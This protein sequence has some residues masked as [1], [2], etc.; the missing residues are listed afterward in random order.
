MRGSDNAQLLAAGL[1]VL[2]TPIAGFDVKRFELPARRDRKR[3]T[4]LPAAAQG[5]D[6]EAFAAL[7]RIH[8]AEVFRLAYRLTRQRQDAEDVVQETFLRAY[9][10]LPQFGGDAAFGTWLHRIA[11]N[12][13]CD[14]LRTRQR[15]PGPAASL[16]EEPAGDLDALTSTAASP[17]RAATSAEAQRRIDAALCGLTASERTAFLL[18]HVEAMPI[19]E[20]GRTLGLSQG[21][22]KQAVFRAVRKLRQILTPLVRPR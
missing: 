19:E 20:I 2:L 3:D 6:M 21:A 11:I 16:D 1:G 12:C 22:A 17:E 13:A 9:R 14:L 5:G 10:R 15:A 18:R 4:A 7:V 8:S